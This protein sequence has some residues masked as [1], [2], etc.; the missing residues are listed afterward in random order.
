M[1]TKNPDLDRNTEVTHFKV[2]YYK[3]IYG[4]LV[5]RVY[6]DLLKYIKN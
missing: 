6:G 1:F 2:N 5:L 4:K 3:N